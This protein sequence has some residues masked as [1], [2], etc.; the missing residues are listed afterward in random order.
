MLAVELIVV[1][2]IEIEEKIRRLKVTREEPVDYFEER[3]L[4]KEI[5]DE[6][7]HVEWQK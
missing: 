3:R 2:E 7:R 1:M 5:A 4:E 6:I